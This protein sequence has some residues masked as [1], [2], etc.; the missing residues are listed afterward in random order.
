[1]EMPRAL[2]FEVLFNNGTIEPAS[3]LKYCNRDIEI[4]ILIEIILNRKF[5]EGGGR[6]F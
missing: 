2:N 4:N 5:N 1:M 6:L 3:T